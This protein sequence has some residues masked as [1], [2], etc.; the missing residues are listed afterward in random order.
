[1]TSHP[2][3]RW[4]APPDPSGVITDAE[5]LGCANCGGDTFCINY[6]KS[7]VGEGTEGVEYHCLSCGYIGIETFTDMGATGDYSD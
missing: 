1:M 7:G 6:T 2:A 4:I 3:T 5:R